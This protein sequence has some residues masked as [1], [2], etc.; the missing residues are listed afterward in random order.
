MAAVTS[1]MNPD[2][3]VPVNFLHSAIDRFV[4][5]QVT[6]RVRGGLQR[7]S[8]FDLIVCGRKNGTG[9]AAKTQ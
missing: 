8:F 9:I 6:F 5:K 7:G 3:W 1:G 4:K 2:L